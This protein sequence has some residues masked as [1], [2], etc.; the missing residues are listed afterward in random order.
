MLKDLEDDISSWFR[1]DERGKAV[2]LHLSDG[3]KE[4]DPKL[5]GLVYTAIKTIQVYEDLSTTGELQG[6]FSDNIKYWAYLILSKCK[7]GVTKAEYNFEEHYENIIPVNEK[8]SQLEAEIEKI[9]DQ[10]EIEKLERVVQ[11]ELKKKEDES[12]LSVKE[13][14]LLDNY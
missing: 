12:S 14:S 8:F 11:K 3:K 7:R 4:I 2:F 9:R 6:R 13:S 10:E 5:N 1:F